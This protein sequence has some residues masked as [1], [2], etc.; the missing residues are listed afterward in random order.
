MPTLLAHSN[1]YVGWVLPKGVVEDLDSG[2]GE[3]LL[4][5]MCQGTGEH[6]A[7]TPRAFSGVEED[8]SLRLLN[9]D[10]SDIVLENAFLVK[11]GNVSRFESFCLANA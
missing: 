8:E 1:C 5:F 2:E 3:V 9:L 11:I 6:T 4:P 7:L 10:H